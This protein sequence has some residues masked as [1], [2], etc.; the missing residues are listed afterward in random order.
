MLYE[1]EGGIYMAIYKIE[2]EGRNWEERKR[3]EGK[4]EKGRHSTM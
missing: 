4:K 2:K 1:K 3:G